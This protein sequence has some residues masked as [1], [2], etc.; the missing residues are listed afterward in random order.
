VIGHPGGELIDAVAAGRIAE[1][2]DAVWVDVAKNHEIL[3][4]HK[5]Q[6]LSPDLFKT[7]VNLLAVASRNKGRLPTVSELA[8]SLRVS[9]QDMQKATETVLYLVDLFQNRTAV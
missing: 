2:I 6:S 1:D 5:V 9:V 3:D 7:L 4:D 8:F